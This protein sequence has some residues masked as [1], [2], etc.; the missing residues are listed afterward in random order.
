MEHHR[1]A[2]A[3]SFLI[4]QGDCM[5][6]TISSNPIIAGIVAI[7]GIYIIFKLIG[8]FGTLLR[9]GLAVAIGAAIIYWLGK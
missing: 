9:L 2:S 5:L 7:V 4:F 8:I 3:S 1:Q 6:E